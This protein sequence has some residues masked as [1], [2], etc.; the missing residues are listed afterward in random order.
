MRLQSQLFKEYCDHDSE[1]SVEV[2][3]LSVTIQHE[4]SIV[5]LYLDGDV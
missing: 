2:T 1:F 3:Q 4:Y 5:F